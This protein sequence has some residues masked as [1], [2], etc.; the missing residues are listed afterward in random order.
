MEDNLASDPNDKKPDDWV[1]APMIDDPE[2]T[3]RVGETHLVDSA[4]KNSD[5]EENFAHQGD[6]HGKCTSNPAYQGL[7][8]MRPHKTAPPTA[9]TPARHAR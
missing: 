4:A 3:M 5:D 8:D 2:D 7:G 6:W 1:D 9:T